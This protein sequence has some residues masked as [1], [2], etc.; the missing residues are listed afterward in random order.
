MTIIYLEHNI[1]DEFD[2]GKTAYLEPLFANKA[3][4]LVI[5]I[6]SVDEIFRSGDDSRSRRNIES[7]K[8]L[9]VR[10]IHSG[11][12]ESEMSIDV[13]D[14]ENIHQMWYQKW[15]EMQSNI[16][17]LND[18]HFQFIRALY[19]ENAPEAFKIM[20]SAINDQISW[21][22]RNYKNMP[23]QQAAM[24]KVLDN[25]EEYKE[26][27][28][29]LICLKS[30]LPFKSKDINNFPEYSFFGLASTS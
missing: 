17:S 26:R 3:C 6:A 21:M 19:C 7:L 30:L 16:G 23:K 18:S 28:M 11:K 8:R 4:L 1:I 15:L 20:V 5:S 13:L 2:K 27:C 14:Y 22:R 9:G 25:P 12:D 24:D 29:Q 10:Y